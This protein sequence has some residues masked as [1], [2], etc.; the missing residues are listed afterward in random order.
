MATLFLLA[1]FIALVI[2]VIVAATSK[3][4][5][6]E[7]SEEEFRAEAERSSLLG[8]AVLGLHKFLQP[9]RVEYVLKRD[10]HPEAEET[11]S[12][13]RPPE[14]TPPDAPTAR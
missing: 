11:E 9:K 7:M 2:G 12:G 14:R 10:K 6:Q 13:D 1:V 3:G 5:Y 4:R 8:S